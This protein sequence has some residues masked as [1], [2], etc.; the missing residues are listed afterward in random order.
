M[1]DS[2]NNTAVASKQVNI[3]S[4]IS[5]GWD[6]VTADMGSFLLL[7]LIYIVI[8]TVASSTVIGE[9]LVIGPLQVGIFYIIFEKMRGKP[10][11]IGDIAKGFNF[12]IAA[13]LSN[14]LI[15][16]FSAIG[17]LLC[18]IPGLIIMALYIFAPPLIVEKNLDFWAAMEESRKVAKEHLFEL[19]LFLF[20]LAL[21]N[22]VGVLVCGIGI[23]FTLPLSFAAIAVGY[24]ELIGVEKE[25]GE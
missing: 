3:G 4:W 6:I 8:V 10:I 9:W 7:G 1:A 5:R 15:S 13:V 17:F 24:D 23:I 22:L 14:I 18:I 20:I 25:P 12:F 16:I 19:T 11:N 21:I 2:Q